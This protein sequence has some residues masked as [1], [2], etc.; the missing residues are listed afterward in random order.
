MAGR[1]IV[2]SNRVPLDG[3]G[4][5]GL[6][7]ALHEA[8]AAEAEGIWIGSEPVEGE[9]SDS[10]REI[11][12][13]TPYTKLTFGLTE[14]DQ[15]DYYLGYANSVLWPLCHR[16]SDLIDYEP[17]FQQAYLGVNGR[18]ARMLAETVRPD[19]RLW[20]HDYHFFP[21]AWRLRRLGVNNRIGFFLHIPFPHAS[22]LPALSD[23]DVFAAWISAYDLVGLQ[24]E[25]DV[26]TCREMFRVDGSA[27]FLKQ[28]YIRHAGRTM[29]LCAFP[30]GIDVDVMR[31][32]AEGPDTPA[33]L[34]L[35]ETERL[36]IGVDRLD[37]SKGIAN[38]VEAFG[39]YLDARGSR[40]P[41]A[42]LMQIAPPTR[43][44]VQA[45]AEIRE[46]LEQLTGRINGAHAEIDWTPIRYIHRMIPREQLA[47]IFRRANAA[48]V[49][50]LADGM[51]LVAKEYIA[52]QGPEDP[53]VLI[54]SR[55]A[56]AAEQLDAALMVNPYDNDE[57][58]RAIDQALEMELWER[59]ERYEAM[60]QEIERHDIEWW[61]T[62]FLSALGS[63]MRVEAAAANA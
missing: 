61:R 29:R 1:L 8:L 2:V 20:I 15:N 38:R 63:G 49:T 5:G 7:V 58:A 50:P 18:L 62:E 32:A 13:G 41:R 12:D 34:R 46:E 3:Q 53:G 28:G 9:A 40:E 11:D 51:N 25:R 33:R 57:M 54:L 45:Y 16:R 37:Y 43:E 47:G 24:T 22:D 31:R 30:I 48:L 6:V 21:L 35:Y 4:S 59:R 23:R 26:S 42:T 17:R 36:I 39:A 52:C 19:D 10:F 27:E 56:G 60:F 55:F 44:D 14:A